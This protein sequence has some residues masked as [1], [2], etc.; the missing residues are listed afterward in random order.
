[1]KKNNIVLLTIAIVTL[2]SLVLFATYAFLSVG[3][4]NV[5]NVANFTARSEDNNMV[6][7]T[8]GGAMSLNVTAASMQRANKGTVAAQNTTTL[9]V[10]FQS[11]SATKI[12]CTYDIVYEWVSTDKYTTHS[13]T[14]TAVNEFVIKASLASNSHVTEGY[15]HIK[16][17]TDISDAVYNLSS[18]VVVASAQ[19]DSTGTTKTLQLGH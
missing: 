6:F 16:N 18:P 14:S 11:N 5:T 1:M 17:E 12:T 4:L 3:N 19:I 2:L 10:N 8:L 9:K 7:D 15:N 13:G